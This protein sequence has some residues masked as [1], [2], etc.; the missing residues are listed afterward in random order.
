MTK[1]MMIL[2]AGLALLP[3]TAVAHTHV[4]RSEPAANAVLH[5]SPKAVKL[6]FS[7]PVTIAFTGAEIADSRGHLFPAGKAM[8][9]M[10]SKDTIEVPLKESL[11]PGAYTVR[12]HAVADDSHR[13]SGKFAF[14]IRP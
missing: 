12:W 3:A 7:E 14:S 4:E 1:S 11:N 2:S 9:A 13:S 5:G 6:T 10:G 8:I